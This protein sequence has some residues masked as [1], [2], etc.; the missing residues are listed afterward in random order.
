MNLGLQLKKDHIW[1]SHLTITLDFLEQIKD[2]QLANQG[3]Q[4][5]V[6]LLG[7]DQAKY[8]ILGADGILRFKS[9]VCIPVKSNLRRMIL[10]EGHKSRLSIHSGMTKMY[11]DLKESF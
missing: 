7:T 2:E 6:G 8:F 4:C 11:K 10:E 9:R 5:T 1:C 3:L